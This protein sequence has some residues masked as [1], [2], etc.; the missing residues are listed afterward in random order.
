[1]KDGLS[2]VK[3][4]LTRRGRQLKKIKKDVTQ[5]LKNKEKL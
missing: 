2:G 1:L 3:Q 5:Y 4:N